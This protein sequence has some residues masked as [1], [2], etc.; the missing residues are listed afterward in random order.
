MFRKFIERPILSSVISIIIVI[1]GVLGIISLPIEQYPDIAPPTIRVSAN[2]TGANAETVLKSV[3]TPLE[4]QINGVEDMT[5]MTS[6][7]SNDGSATIQVYFKQGTDADMAA[8]NVQNRVARATALL[9][10][11]VTRA[12][13]ITAKR[14]NSMLM[15]FSLYNEDGQYDETFLQN[16]SRI[17]VIPQIQRINGVGEA[18]VF[19]AKDY[20]MRIWL[21]PDVMAAYNLVPTDVIAAL[22]E[23]NLEAAPGRLGEQNNQSFEYVLKYKGK[24]TQP[25]EFEDIIIKAD[26]DGNILRLTDIARIE[27]GAL[28]YSI[29]TSTQGSPGI[30]MAVFQS[31]GSNAR[32]VIIEAKEVLEEASKS[33]PPGITYEILM[34]ANQ[35]LDSSIE[36]V[37]HTLIEA[38]ILVFIVV[39]VFLQNFRATLIPAISVPVAIVGTFFF[40]NI[41][42]FTINLLTLFALIL[43]IGIVVDDA[44]VVV[45]AVHAKLDKGAKNAK[46]AAVSAMNEIST[47]IVSITLVMSAVFV[48][49]AFITGTTGVFYKQFGITLAISIILSAINALTLS[50]ALCAIF[51]KPHQHD[52]EKKQS[53]LQRFYTS[54]NVAFDAM[55]NKYKH[56]TSFLMKKRW[57]S[58]VLIIAFSGALYFLM[59]TT[60]TGF[61]PAEDTGRMFV[62]ISLPPATSMEETRRIANQVDAI[63]A[64]TPEVES[65]STVVGM[66]LI[67][68]RGSSYGM[69]I[70]NLKPFEERED[71]GEDLN[72][73]IGKLYG[74]T[75]QIK[76]A[77]IIIFT[78]PMV[79]GF[80]I[81]GGI[82][83]K[84]EDKTGGDIKKFE[85]ISKNFLGKLN[86]RP[87]VQYATTS[88][89]TNFPQYQ[90]DVNV[91]RCKQ[92]GIPVNSVLTTLQGYIGGYYASDFNRFGKQY[93]IM[94][95]SEANYRGN[96][97][98]LNNIY[99]RTPSGEMAPITEFINLKRVYGPENIT[100]FNMYTS[101]DV[102]GAPNPGYSTGDAIL[103]VQE[104]AAETLPTGYGYEFSGL[105]REELKSGNQSIIIFI[106]SL[107]FVY[108]LLAAQYESFLLPLSIIFSLPIGIAG[109]FI[110]ARIMGVENNI[111]LQISL[112]MLIG[113]LAKN[114]ILIVEFALQRRQAGMSIVQSAIEGATARLRPILMTSFAFIFGLIPLVLATGVGANGNRSIGVGAVGGMLIGTMIGI[115][116]IPSMYV[117]FQTLQEKVKKPE[118]KEISELNSFE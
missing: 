10:S 81:S 67:S 2:Y 44:I 40:L 49:V 18:M 105:T 86:Q 51:L 112:I 79:P 76:D 21:K 59:K 5:Y 17:N 19:G 55:T 12:G 99:I 84:L 83:L 82:E 26:Q 97:E 72:S 90:V 65:R 37:I 27:L 114:A 3:V 85:E 22:N 96:P 100:R 70:C 103:A 104:V 25:E 111:Y 87:E 62:D 24:L 34:D 33:F 89:N 78:P 71:E 73:V 41:F 58:P 53:Y 115:L 102:N 48:P 88:F 56:T 13:V 39:F 43:A 106:L 74:A 63:L 11:E 35:F 57:I 118:I 91:A 23:Q 75:S 110:F 47:A 8:V 66:S 69:V 38:F 45:E 30:A 109:S 117:L 16:Y 1:L 98:D 6:T 77:R 7:A 14:Q 15:V 46:E 107:I 94:V 68:G 4:E 116:V 101:I 80:S 20:S 64:N 50:P 95:Q 54:F 92:S 31:A 93:R 36:K 9:P 29:S 52:P 113:L 61:V 28:N 42:G 108:F 60:P 32:E